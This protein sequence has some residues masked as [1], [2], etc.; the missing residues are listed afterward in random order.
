MERLVVVG[1]PGRLPGRVDRA[2]WP[3]HV[4]VLPNF[5]VEEPAVASVTSIVRQA[6]DRQPAFSVD[7]GPRAVFGPGHDVP[8]LLADHPVF[9]ALHGSLSGSVEPLPGFR[10][11]HTEFWGTGY[12]PHATIVSGAEAAVARQIMITYLA[13]ASLDGPRA[14][15][16]VNCS[17]ARHVEGRTSSR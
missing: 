17:L 5:V 13:V 2:D 10:P 1:T 14:R 7:L 11:D 12:R 4:T 3:E 8:V 9:H 15:V 6:A 16:L